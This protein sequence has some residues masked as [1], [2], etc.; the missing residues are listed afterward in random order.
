MAGKPWLNPVHKVKRSRTEGMP[1]GVCLTHNRGVS[2][3][4]ALWVYEG[5]PRKVSFS[6]RKYG[7]SGAFNRAVMARE[8]GILAEEERLQEKYAE[9]NR[10]QRN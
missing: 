2:E 5:K 8:F 4:Q 3:I 7:F 6:V 9:L 1:I 10:V